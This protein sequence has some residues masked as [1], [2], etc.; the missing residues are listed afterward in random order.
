MA[1]RQREQALKRYYDAPN[2]CLMC[3]KI[4][5]IADGQ[6][7]AIARRKKFCNHSC[8]A[9]HTSNNPN[10]PK[11]SRA[12]K[13]LCI[14]CGKTTTRGI[15]ICRMC[16]RIE[17]LNGTIYHITKGDL[18]KSKGYSVTREFIRKHAFRTFELSGT[19]KIC[20]ICGYSKHIEVCHIKSVSDFPSS[21][22]ILEIN[23]LK[24]LIALCPTHHWELDNKQLD[25][26]KW[27]RGLDLNQ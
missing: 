5:K 15:Q 8:A 3:N 10:K 1:L 11:W 7:V 23:N 25:D 2:I 27:L 22:T 18:F 26:P 17:K 24:N 14:R 9:L 12:L 21:A 4:I 13:H 20:K 19:K 6:K 16:C